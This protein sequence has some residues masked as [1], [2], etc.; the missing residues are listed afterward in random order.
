MTFTNPNT[1][2]TD[3]PMKFRA[4]FAR[5]RNMTLHPERFWKKVAKYGPDDCWPFMGKISSKGYGKFQHNKVIWTA[6][7]FAYLLTHGDSFLKNDGV[8]HTCDNRKCCNPNHLFT[9]SIQL[10]VDDMMAKGRNN[11]PKGEKSPRS[12]LREY[13]VRDIRQSYIPGVVTM[14]SLAIRYGVREGHIWGIIKR[15]AWKCIP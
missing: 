8:F 11:Q 12:K 3:I 10:N 14:K 13:Q 9:G 6:H 5:W 4:A 2:Y 1:P 15:V 7:R